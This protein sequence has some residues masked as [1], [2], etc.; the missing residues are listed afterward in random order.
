MNPSMQYT[1]SKAVQE[2]NLEILREIK[3]GGWLAEGWSTYIFGADQLTQD[4]LQQAYDL[5]DA[6]LGGKLED[7]SA[8][9]LKKENDAYNSILKLHLEALSHD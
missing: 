8:Q 2:V 7:I 6:V 3:E 4:E 1:V 5:S 9:N